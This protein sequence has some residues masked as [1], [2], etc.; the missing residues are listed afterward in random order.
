MKLEQRDKNK[1]NVIFPCRPDKKYFAYFVLAI[2]AVPT[3]TSFVYYSF[4]F[5]H[6]VDS[7]DNVKRTLVRN[8]NLSEDEAKKFSNKNVTSSYKQYAEQQ[9]YQEAGFQNLPLKVILPTAILLIIFCFFTLRIYIPGISKNVKSDSELNIKRY[10]GRVMTYLSNLNTAIIT[11]DGFII[12]LLG[13]SLVSSGL[14]NFYFF[15]GFETIIISLISCLASYP[16]FIESSV[17]SQ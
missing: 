4:V 15:L 17:F 1:K 12:S 5:P 3:L 9:A 7:F 13:A 2:A 6:S 8:G 16:T 14:N 11:V 10:T